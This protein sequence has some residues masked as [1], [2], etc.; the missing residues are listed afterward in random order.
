MPP[1]I[2]G[3]HKNPDACHEAGSSDLDC[4][5]LSGADIQQGHLVYGNG[6]YPRS[7]SKNGLETGHAIRELMDD[8]EAVSA[9]LAGVVEVDEAY[10][11]GAPKFKKGVKNKWGR[12]TWKAHGA[13]CG[14]SQRAGKGNFDP[15]C[16]G[17]DTRAD[18]ERVD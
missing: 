9:R 16:A 15:E 6:A 4:R 5:N 17:S 12:G 3:H 2:H 14:R 1:S 8:R 7:K 10:V 13:G 11:G 18:H